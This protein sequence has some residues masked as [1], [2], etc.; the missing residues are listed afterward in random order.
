[1]DSDEGAE[2]EIVVTRIDENG[3]KVQTRYTAKLTTNGEGNCNLNPKNG[4]PVYWF[5]KGSVQEIDPNPDKPTDP[6][7]PSNPGKPTD[8]TDPDKPT[9]PTDPSDPGK[10]SDPT[11]P[12]KPNE[13]P[14]GEQEPDNDVIIVTDTKKAEA[15][16]TNDGDLDKKPDVPDEAVP[17]AKAPV[18]GDISGLWL[19]LS[20]LSGSGMLLNNRKRKKK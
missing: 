8:P 13:N 5:A 14:D 6:T 16:A 20:G 3:K 12:S 10:P 1:M 19:A 2:V 15:T 11:E 9:D 4:A 17:L 7:E 18:T